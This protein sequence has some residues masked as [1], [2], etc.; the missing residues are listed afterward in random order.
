MA[1]TTYA[2]ALG[3]GAMLV[4]HDFAY[5]SSLVE[6]A[7]FTEPTLFA[8]KFLLAFPLTF[9]A[10]NGIRHLVWDAGKCLTMK[11]VYNTG[12]ASLFVAVGSAV[13][14]SAI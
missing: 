7:N 4:P 5:Y 8:L 6:A 13:W 9:H 2:T 14:L 12:Y 11:Y 1:L 10:T 3:C